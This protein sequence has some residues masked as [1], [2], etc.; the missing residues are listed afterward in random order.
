MRR[1]P[2]CPDMTNLSSF[3]DFVVALAKAVVKT[4]VKWDE[5]G[6]HCPH[7]HAEADYPHIVT[8]HEPDCIVEQAENFLGGR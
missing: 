3:D 2:Y 6:T 8:E 5:C 4:G 1:K 7:C